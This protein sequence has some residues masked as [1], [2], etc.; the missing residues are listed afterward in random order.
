MNLAP[1]ARLGC[2]PFTRGESGICGLSD[3]CRL[4]GTLVRVA[5]WFL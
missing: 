1:L 3:A 2:S 4:F 5:D